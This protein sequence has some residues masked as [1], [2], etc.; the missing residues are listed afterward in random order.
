MPYC[1]VFRCLIPSHSLRLTS[2]STIE[3]AP[4]TSGSGEKPAASPLK[5]TLSHLHSLSDIAAAGGVDGIAA[6]LGSSLSNGLPASR[7]AANR[8]AYGRNRLEDRASRS[9]WSHLGEALEDDT[10]RILLASAFFSIL[11]AAFFSTNSFVDAVQGGAIVAAAVIV[12]GVNSFQNWSKDREFKALAELKRDFKCHVVRDGSTLSISVYDLVV[13]DLLKVTAGDRLPCDGILLDAFQLEINQ[14]S[15]TGES[16]LVK[17]SVEVD[18][19]IIGGCMAQ[20]GEGTYLATAVGAASKMGQTVSLVENE[21]VGNTPLQDKL[22]ELAGDIGRL[23]MGVG[24]LTFLV[25]TVLW[26]YALEGEDKW[27][28]L[29]AWS[30]ASTVLRFFIVGLA[31]VVVAVPEGLP[32]AV[33]ISLAFSMRR[34]MKDNNLVRQ[35]QACETMG[36]AT[37]I[38]SDKTGTQLTA[39]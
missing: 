29:L 36:S 3:M 1:C 12:S 13:G 34:M 16:L 38:A 30:T 9:F 32:L 28:N 2:L 24:T 35:L 22:E 25:L 37:V 33:T 21:E 17:K 11:F 26:L 15:M 7:I 8:E 14:S 27:T 5:D 4:P 20:Q 31:I 19:F 39:G 23:G 10:L 6:A 18:P